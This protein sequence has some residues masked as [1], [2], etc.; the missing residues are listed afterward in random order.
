MYIH[1]L[2]LNLSWEGNVF[3]NDMV[4]AIKFVFLHDKNINKIK[5]TEL[6]DSYGHFG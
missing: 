4:N 5:I 2:M 1:H 3:I 6:S